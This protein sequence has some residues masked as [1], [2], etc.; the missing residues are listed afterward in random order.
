MKVSLGRGIIV[1]IQWRESSL[2]VQKML[3]IRRVRLSHP[4]KAQC[5]GALGPAMHSE[6]QQ[7]AQCVMKL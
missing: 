4:L 6:W 5:M 7:A 1:T 2:H 3:L